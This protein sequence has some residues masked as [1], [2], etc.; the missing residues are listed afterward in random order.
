MKRNDWDEGSYVV[1]VV[2]SSNSADDRR[3]FD[4][5]SK[6]SELPTPPARPPVRQSCAAAAAR[7]KVTDRVSSDSVDDAS[8]VHRCVKG[9]ETS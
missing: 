6:E 1:R 2:P 8:N 5:S 7:E 4:N 3:I 9:A